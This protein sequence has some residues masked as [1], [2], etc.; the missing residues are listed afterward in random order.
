LNVFD[1]IWHQIVEPIVT[2]LDL[3]RRR[4]TSL[5]EVA[6]SKRPRLHWCPTGLFSFLP[7]HAA[8]PSNETNVWISDYVVSSYTPTLTA[9][10]QTRRELQPVLRTSLRALLAAAPSV[11]GLTP[12]EKAFEELSSVSSSLS[13]ASA[14]VI[15]EPP[16]PGRDVHVLEITSQLHK[17]HILHLACHGEQDPVN[18]LQ[19]GFC[20]CDGKL[21]VFELMRLSA[22]NA[23]LAFL[24]A[25]ETAKGDDKQ[26]DQAVHLAAAMLFVGFRSVIATMW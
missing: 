23:L 8:G 19:S 16:V 26:P 3:E 6:A 2:A 7:L 11:E 20:F 22:P 24:S 21:T 4:T 1:Q 18:P 17:A 12:L 10:I 5:D 9:L 15:G 25:C 14:H 13:S